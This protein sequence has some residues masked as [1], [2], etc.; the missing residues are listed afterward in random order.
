MTPDRYYE[1][2]AWVEQQ[3]VEIERLRA[4]VEAWRECAKYDPL[5][6]GPRFKGWDRSALDRCRTRFIELR[7]EQG[8][9]T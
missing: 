2:E 8:P 1:L 3:R 6:E 9:T 4:E 7:A 5:M